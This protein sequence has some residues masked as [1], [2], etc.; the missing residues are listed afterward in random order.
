MNPTRK[1]SLLSSFSVGAQSHGNTHQQPAAPRFNRTTRCSAGAFAAPQRAR[2]QG[3]TTKKQ[4]SKWC[5]L[6]L[7]RRGCPSLSQGKMMGRDAVA[8]AP[9]QC[10]SAHVTERHNNKK[11]VAMAHFSFSSLNQNQNLFHS[12]MSPSPTF[13][14]DACPAVSPTIFLNDASSSD[15][16]EEQRLFT[17]PEA[18]TI[19]F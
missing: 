8:R 16:E 9:S 11:Y 7:L 19:D 12:N 10:L 14:N 6:F 1:K 2:S 18:K 17:Q 4:Q 3:K 15:E 13:L 5:F